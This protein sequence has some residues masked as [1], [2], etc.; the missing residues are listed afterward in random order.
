MIPSCLLV[1]IFLWLICLEVVSRTSCFITFPLQF[2]VDWPLVSWVL[3]PLWG[4]SPSHSGQSEVVV[5]VATQQPVLLESV[6]SSFRARGQGLLLVASESV[7]P[8]AAPWRGVLFP[9][10][11]MQ[12]CDA[13][14]CVEERGEK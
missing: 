10:R 13:H 12:P 11:N 2:E 6:G 1:M 3:L 5:S 7:P 9:L 4:T 8:P 14:C